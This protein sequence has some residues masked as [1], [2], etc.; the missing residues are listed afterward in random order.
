MFQCVA[1]PVRR[2]SV[3]LIAMKLNE[4]CLQDYW[5]GKLYL[6]EFLQ[7]APNTLPSSIIHSYCPCLAVSVGWGANYSCDCACNHVMV[8]IEVRRPNPG[9]FSCIQASSFR[10]VC[11][12]RTCFGLMGGLKCLYS[13][14]VTASNVPDCHSVAT[15]FRNSIRHSARGLSV[16]KRSCREVCMIKIVILL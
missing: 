2:I 14:G 13:R 6:F 1:T 11:K 7:E 15:S 8:P 10:G 12:M 16:V 5:C 3:F 9:T 4:Q